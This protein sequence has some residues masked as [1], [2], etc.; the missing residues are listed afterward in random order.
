[1]PR[2]SADP[3]MDSRRGGESESADALGGG[4]VKASAVRGIK[5]GITS[6]CAFER[7][8][9]LH[10]NPENPRTITTERLEALKAAL[11]SDGAMLQARPLIALPDGTVIAGNQRL[12]AAQELGWETIPVIR[13]DLDEQTA[14]LWMLRDNSEYGEWDEPALGEILAS[15]SFRE[16]AARK[17]EYGEQCRACR[18]LPMCHGGCQKHRL[19]TSAEVAAPSYFCAAYERL[20]AHSRRQLRRFADRVGQA[21]RA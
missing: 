2:E 15:P 7:I 4:G 14:R 5:A 6:N 10:S 8:A 1:M 13:V 16:F 21:R 3:S 19:V 9:D 12:R 17:G 18:W 20:F 11:E